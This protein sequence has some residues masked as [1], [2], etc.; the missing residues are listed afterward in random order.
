MECQIATYNTVREIL[1]NNEDFTHL[2]V[3][4]CL[5]GKIT[6]YH[7]YIWLY[8]DQVDQLEKRMYEYRKQI[9]SISLDK[10]TREEYY[11]IQDACEKTGVERLLIAR[12]L[13]EKATCNGCVWFRYY[14]QES[15]QAFENEELPLTVFRRLSKIEVVKDDGT[16]K[17]CKSIQEAADFL[18]VNPHTVYLV[19]NKKQTIH[20]VDFKVYKKEKL[21]E[22]E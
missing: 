1:D 10:E 8:E 13:R 12:A 9:V 16:K 19:L 20:P 22:T 2:G 17:E 21:I 7:Y 3:R 14:D 18:K 15:I 5:N 4:N 6:H 11:S